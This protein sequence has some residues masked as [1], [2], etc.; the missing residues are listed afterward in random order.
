MY[1]Q[2]YEQFVQVHS[3]NNN[4]SVRLQI[5]TDFTQGQKISLLYLASIFSLLGVRG[6]TKST[7]FLL[8]YA[9]YKSCVIPASQPVRSES[10]VLRLAYVIFVCLIAVH[11][12]FFC[13]FC[14][15]LYIFK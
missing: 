15:C 6:L 10:E 9:P 14:V 2:I 13:I 11:I 4:Y 12:S 5:R 7:T 3:D 1:V 8:A